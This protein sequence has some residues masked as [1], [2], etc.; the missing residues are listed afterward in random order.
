VWEVLKPSSSRDGEASHGAEL[1]TISTLDFDADAL[2]YAFAY[3]LS[4]PQAAAFIVAARRALAGIDCLG[5]GLAHRILASVQRAHWDPPSDDMRHEGA[6]HQR[7]SKLTE[8]APIGEVRED[9]A[10]QALWLRRA[11]V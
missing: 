2:I 9:R 11:P 7:R 8:A 6:R 3:P 1:V 4:P 10:R 5:P